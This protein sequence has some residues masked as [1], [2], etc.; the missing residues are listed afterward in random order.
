[1]KPGLIPHRGKRPALRLGVAGC[2]TALILFE[3][4]GADAAAKGPGLADLSLEQLM[5]IPV[6]TVQSASKYEQKITQAPASVTI[7]TAAEI[8]AFGH[9]TL[10]D[11][12][13]SVR[14]LYV[15]DDR[16]YSYLGV[17]GFLRPG[18]YNSRVLVLV[19]G[20][21][22]NDTIYDAT[23]YGRD[24]A[25]AMEAID[26]VEVI[27]GPSSSI[28]GNSAFFGVVNLV[29]KRGAQLDGTEVATE[30]GSFGSHRGRISYGRQFASGAD[31]SLTATY[32][33][34]NGEPE[35]YYP[36]F[37]PRVSSDPRAAQG[38]LAL[39]SDAETAF[40]FFG[41]AAYRGLTFSASLS[42][43]TKTV[44]TASFGTVFGDSRYRTTDDRG[45][46]DLAYDR[47]LRP[48]VRLLARAYYDL[49]H[50]Y[51]DY[52]F[53]LV[54]LGRPSDTV[55]NRDSSTGGWA[56]TEWQLTAKVANR[57]TL[58]AGAEFRENIEQ[59]QVSY[60]E[61]VPRVYT[62]DDHRRSRTLALYAQGEFTL[63]PGLLLNTGLRFDQYFGSFG[64]TFNPRVG[65]IFNPQER[66]TVKLLYGRAFRAPNVYER[67][68]YPTPT[69][70][71]DPEHI[72]TYEIALEHYFTHTHR[73]SVS[74][75]TYRVTDL[76]TQTT[77]PAATTRE[78][79]SL[80]AIYF[81]NLDRAQAKGLELELE[82]KY[83]SGLRLRTSY[84]LQ[85]TEDANTGAELS[86]SP[87]HL[88]KAGVTQTFAHER[89]TA[90]LELQYQSAVRTLAGRSAG[91]FVL[92]NLT[93]TH[94]LAP[95][96]E[97]SASVHNLFNTRH[98]YPGGEENAQDVIAQPPRTF[99]FRAAYKF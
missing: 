11:V 6:E 19:D 98:A 14:G 34:S 94:R 83:S 74:A 56:G 82:G 72:S 12:L 93:L 44:P 73:V 2:C 80:D 95:G 69:G 18:D 97:L 41:K 26:R 36:E 99:T 91:D 54:G 39:K 84:A 63:A 40:G 43:R 17:R 5:D 92:G 81:A 68:Y 86:S 75:Y 64:S 49:Y 25:L 31:V 37:D 65:L 16:N 46:V 67:F 3:A 59:D 20:H 8:A 70:R 77:A 71:L 45:Y 58:V 38:G 21:R 89:F 88:A 51:G 13:R 53:D 47:E 27:R 22:M 90:G 78:A 30:A 33:H 29:T 15:S 28:Y 42:S 32:F 50:Y 61:Q 7:V 48:D 9:R 87:R 24:N 4:R 96:F 76:I 10:A 1:M 79:T 66:T 23:Y 60:Y 55:F 57:H 52:P 62:T 85:R 35:L